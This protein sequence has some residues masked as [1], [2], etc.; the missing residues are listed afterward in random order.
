MKERRYELN[1]ILVKILG[2]KNIY[3]QPPESIKLSYDCIVYKKGRARKFR[4]DNKLYINKD[5][6]ELLVMSKNP[7][8]DIADRLEQSL[9]Y[10]E[11][12]RRY[13]T[14]NICHDVLYLYY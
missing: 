9:N 11:H 6:Y 10:C 1:R 13:I 3:Y 5:F 8:N 7:D 12:Q 4:A 14:N 2:S